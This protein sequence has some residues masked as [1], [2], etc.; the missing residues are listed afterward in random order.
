VSGQS[1]KV[2]TLRGIK[3]IAQNAEAN[4]SNIFQKYGAE[5][6]CFSYRKDPRKKGVGLFLW[7]YAEVYF[8]IPR[9]RLWL[10]YNRWPR[11]KVA[12][13]C[14]KKEAFS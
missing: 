14:S 6:T 2:M 7:A 8:R 13:L 12:L 11:G 3:W 4:S 9:A 1:G 10:A 5:R